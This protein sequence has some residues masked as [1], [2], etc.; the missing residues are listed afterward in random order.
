[1]IAINRMQR[2]FDTHRE[3]SGG[4]G[5]IYVAAPAI[6]T[7]GHVKIGWTSNPRDRLASFNTS[8][9]CEWAGTFWKIDNS[10]QWEISI[11][12][13]MS[14]WRIEHHYGESEI[15]DSTVAWDGHI[16]KLLLGDKDPIEVAVFLDVMYEICHHSAIDK[17]LKDKYPLAFYRHAWDFLR[18]M[19]SDTIINVR[20]VFRSKSEVWVPWVFRPDIK[21]YRKK[22][23]CLDHRNTSELRQQVVGP[24]IPNAGIMIE[25]KFFADNRHVVV[26][27]KKSDPLHKQMEF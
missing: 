20:D 27:G 3:C 18:D 14:A 7:L 2:E 9:P 19:D 25:Q 15:I 23:H 17:N 11:L 24:R 8:S 5:F 16:Y 13:R 6:N 1:M 4:D 22:I 12:E 26:Y 10:K 21:L